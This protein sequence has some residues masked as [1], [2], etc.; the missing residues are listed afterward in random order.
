MAF[1]SRIIAK[2]LAEA[3][4]HEEYHH[5]GTDRIAELEARV[6][7][8]EARTKGHHYSAGTGSSSGSN[9]GRY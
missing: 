3:D 8:L 6:A 5:G 1:L 7:A 2:I 9:K 4:A